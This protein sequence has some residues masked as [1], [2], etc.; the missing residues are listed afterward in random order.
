LESWDWLQ[1]FKKNKVWDH[2][3]AKQFFD[4]FFLTK[5]EKK[6]PNKT[7]KMIFF[8]NKTVKMIF[9]LTKQ[10]TFFSERNRPNRQRQTSSTLTTK[11]C[12]IQSFYFA[13]VSREKN[14]D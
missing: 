7:A 12:S 10:L 9:Y 13:T 8:P 5:P 6:F 3:V 4:D 11:L 2:P 14:L 1:Y